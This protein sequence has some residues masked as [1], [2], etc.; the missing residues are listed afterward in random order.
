M[1][2]ALPIEKISGG[3][4]R[5]GLRWDVSLELISYCYDV[6]VK[7]PAMYNFNQF[8]YVVVNKN[9]GENLGRYINCSKSHILPRLHHGGIEGHHILLYTLVAI[10]LM[11]LLHLGHNEPSPW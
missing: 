1:Y 2:G 3:E 4:C 6:C 9:W 7:A 10:M 11:L 5:Q 8:S